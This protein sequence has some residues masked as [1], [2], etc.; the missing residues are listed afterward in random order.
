MTLYNKWRPTCL[1]MIVGQEPVKRI[2]RNQINSGEVA[3]SYLFVGPAGTGKTTVARI[4][5]AMVNDSSGLTL[6]PNLEDE[7]VKNIFSGRSAIDV[8]EVDAAS[9]GKVDDA[10]EIRQKADYP[11]ISMR[12]KIW[13]IDECHA[14][15]KD[16]WQ[17]MLKVI[18]EPP[19]H[20]IFV[21]CT[22]EDD[23]VPETIKTRCMCLRFM[24]LSVQE[25]Q[26][27]I[28]EIADKEGIKANDDVLRMVAYGSKGSVRMA[29]KGLEQAASLGG[30]ITP[31]DVTA[32]L[33]TPDKKAARI[34]VE[35]VISRD[36]LSGI[37]ASSAALTSGVSPEDF[38]S[39]VA[40][41]CHDMIVSK[42]SQFDME[43]YGYT[44]EEAQEISA[45][46]EKMTQSG[47]KSFILLTTKWIDTINAAAKLVVY[48]IQPQ[49][50]LNVL[51]VNMY[52]DFHMAVN[53]QNGGSAGKRAQ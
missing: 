28:K 10:R 13:I 8:I 2:L 16:A 30:E 24:S 27:H 11:A 12:Y 15:S 34:F 43:N 36:F 19:P 1:D 32:T 6:K 29:V 35:S 18:E 46:R 7:S 25:I 50:Q 9:A 26:A 33:G 40:E 53:S 17:A 52:H 39:A 51:W 20:V 41:F 45:C 42:S 22:T 47:V 44:P 23:K 49:C 31:A 5:A 38:M 21:F 3:H 4:L 37:E 14:M 48:R